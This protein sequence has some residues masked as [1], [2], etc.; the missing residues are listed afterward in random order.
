MYCVAI[1]EDMQGAVPVRELVGRPEPGDP[2]SGGIGERLSQIGG[3]R[4][5]G[6]RLFEGPDDGLGLVGKKGVCKRRLAVE[7]RSVGGRKQVGQFRGRAFQ[8][9][10]EIG[11]MPPA[12]RLLGAARA[13]QL[14]N[15]CRQERIGMLPT[16]QIQALESFV[17]KIQGMAGICKSPVGRRRNQHFSD[18]MR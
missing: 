10:N 11:R 2:Q 5:L 9:R 13:H 8:K 7:R 17:D 1:G 15:G 16:D 4:A 6:D 12:V 18:I 3:G 14:A